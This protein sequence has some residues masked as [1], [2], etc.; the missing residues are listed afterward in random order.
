VAFAFIFWSSVE[1][2]YT[3]LEKEALAICW[4]CEMFYYILKNCQFMV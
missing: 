4:A 1:Q 3:Q 2:Q